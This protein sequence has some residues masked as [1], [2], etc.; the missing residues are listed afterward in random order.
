MLYFSQ[1]RAALSLNFRCHSQLWSLEGSKVID[2]FSFTAKHHPNQWHI[3]PGQ[4]NFCKKLKTITRIIISKPLMF[5]ATFGWS[6]EIFLTTSSWTLKSCYGLALIFCEFSIRA[7]ICHEYHES[8]YW[9]NICHVEKFLISI[10]NLNN[11]WS[12]IEIYAVFVLIFCGEKSV[13]RKS[14]WI[15]NDEYQVCSAYFCPTTSGSVCTSWAQYL[16]KLIVH[17]M[18]LT[19]LTIN[20]WKLIFSSFQKRRL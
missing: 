3:L 4:L 1:S 19:I 10:K 13:W 14:L 6:C 17:L 20:F 11:L 9:R 16:D 7:H 5:E 2:F 12:F 15:K 18:V 8:Y